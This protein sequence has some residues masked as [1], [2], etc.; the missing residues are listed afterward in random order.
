MLIMPF[1]AWETKIIFYRID[2]HIWKE[3]K[4]KKQTLL[5]HRLARKIIKPKENINKKNNVA[6]VSD[7]A[8]VGL[9]L[10]WIK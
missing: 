10:S 9:K 5:I 7:I 2:A 4:Q 6:L 8:A 3:S 1:V